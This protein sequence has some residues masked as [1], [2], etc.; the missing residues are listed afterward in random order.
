MD[1]NRFPR[2]GMDY[3]CNDKH[4]VNTCP[5]NKNENDNC[6]CVDQPIALAMSYV[7]KQSLGNLYP[8]FEGLRNG[9]IFPELNLPYCAGG[10]RR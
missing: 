8:L 2:R 6:L 4:S 7:K 1:R 10:S 3:R 5:I 9:T